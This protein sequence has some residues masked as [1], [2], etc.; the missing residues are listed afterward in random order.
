MTIKP[1][2]KMGTQK[3]SQPS[4]ALQNFSKSELALLL[5]DMHDTMLKLE[6][7]GIAAPQIGVYQRVIMFGFEHN[8]RY[9]EED[10]VPFTILINP[11]YKPLSDEKEEDWEGCLSIPGLRGLVSRFKKIKYSGY[12]QEGNLIER[13]AEGFHARVVQHECDHVNGFLY[14]QRMNDMGE[15]GFEE[16]LS[17]RI[18]GKAGKKK[19]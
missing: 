3:L 4:V 1:I 13:N 5:K 14:P 18:H 12:D 16:E 7:V 2:V 9:P 6:G 8:D 10:A 19:K 15:F 11:S 17:V